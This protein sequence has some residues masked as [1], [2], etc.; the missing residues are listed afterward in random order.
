MK[1]SVIMSS[2]LSDYPNCA[3]CRIERFHFA[4]KSFINQSYKD[5]E[6]I[7]VS[8]NCYITKKE[9]ENNYK[10]NKRIK[11]YFSE[12][13]KF[14]SGKT[15]QKGI[16]LALGDFICYL[17]SDDFFGK[18]HLD[19]IF[20]KFDFKKYDWCYYDDYVIIG[21][22]FINK[23][24]KREVVIEDKK[25]VIGTCSFCHKKELNVIWPDGYGHD[26]K[27]VE[28]LKDYPYQKIKGGE[29]FICH[30]PRSSVEYDLDRPDFL[31]MKG[32]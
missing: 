2:L 16:E 29:Y 19:N 22:R 8:D 11:F 13:N 26:H 24:K 15:R 4:V 9:Y 28:Q 10:N 3:T 5:S 25:M 30:Q 27:I 21:N 18:N 6:L 23:F 32:F 17:D 20:N 12:K 14:F 1:F 31:I 7:I